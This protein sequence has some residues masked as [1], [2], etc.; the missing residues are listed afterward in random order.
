MIVDIA[1][2]RFL[3]EAYSMMSL[4]VAVTAWLMPV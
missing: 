1:E 2:L 3:L 4:T